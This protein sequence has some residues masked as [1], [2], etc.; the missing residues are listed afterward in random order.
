MNFTKIFGFPEN[1]MIDVKNESPEFDTVLMTEDAIIRVEVFE[2]IID[3]AKV[4]SVLNDIEAVTIPE[5]TLES[6][7][8]DPNAKIFWW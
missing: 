5:K 3:F 8:D 1:L 2:N 6:N 7:L 4:D